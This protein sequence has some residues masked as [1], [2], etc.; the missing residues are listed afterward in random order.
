MITVRMPRFPLAFLAISIGV[1]LAP[2]DA[3]SAVRLQFDRVLV[4]P[5]RSVYVETVGRPFSGMRDVRL[6]LAPAAAASKIISVSDRRLVPAARLRVTASGSAFASFRVPALVE[7]TY[8]TFV[9]CARCRTMPGRAQSLPG[10]LRVFEVL[11]ECKSA[12]SGGFDARVRERGLRVGPLLFD[13]GVGHSFSTSQ[14]PPYRAKFPLQIETDSFVTLI[15]PRDE[16]QTVS[17]AY[18]A[19]QTATVTFEPCGAVTWWNGGVVVSEPKC[20]TLHARI[21]GRRDLLT[22]RLPAGRPCS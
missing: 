11:R 16:R 13:V 1:A 14:P 15:V 8:A 20:A 17:L 2:A 6:F 3:S 18:T 4:E 10:P 5:G 22:V 19:R 12:P 7:G 9:Y 21:A